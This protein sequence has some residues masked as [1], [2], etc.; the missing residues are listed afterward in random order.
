[1]VLNKGF[2]NKDN[3]CLKLG[4]V[5]KLAHKIAQCF[6]FSLWKSVCI[7]V[8]VTKQFLI[9]RFLVFPCLLKPTWRELELNPGPFVLQATALTIRPWLLRSG[10]SVPHCFT[11]KLLNRWQEIYFG[12]YRK[13]D[14]HFIQNFFSQLLSWSTLQMILSKAFLDLECWAR[15]L[16]P[17]FQ[18]FPRLGPDPVGELWWKL[19][20][21]ANHLKT[22]L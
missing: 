6:I 5:T 22:F 8:F 10:N 1:M 9:H 15:T 3:I 16:W 18:N 2:W 19:G 20:L 7:V 4:F 14:E 11:N 13:M 21:G 17:V 12:N